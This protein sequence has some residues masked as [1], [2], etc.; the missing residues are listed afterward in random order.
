M[1]A[2]PPWTMPYAGPQ[3]VDLV[4]RI[5]LYKTNP[6][7]ENPRHFVKNPLS[8]FLINPHSTKILRRPLVFKI[9]PKILLAAF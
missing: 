8:F 6:E 2:G 5:S 4:N 7:L 1:V 3:L 9:F